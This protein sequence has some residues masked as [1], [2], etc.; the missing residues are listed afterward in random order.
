MAEAAITFLLENLQKLLS[1]HVHLISGAEGELKQLQNELDLMKAFLVQSA[2]RRE[3][4]ELFRQFEIQI[5]D[6]VHEAEDT[7][8]TCLVE[9]AAGMKRNFLSRNLNPKGAS[10]AKK[11]K[12]L[13]ETEVKPIFERAKINFANL[14]IADP[15]ATGDE[16]TKGKAKKIPLL[17]EDNI[18]GFE[19]EADTLISYLN[20]ESEELEVISIIGMPGLGKTTLAWKIY[21]DSRVQFEFPTMIWVYVSQE[22]NRRDVF[23]TILKKFTQVDMSS[24]T[25]NELAC[26]VRSYLEKSKFILF[27]DDVWTTEDWKNIEAALPKGNKLGKVLITSRHERVAV[28]ANR[29][30]EPHQLR[31]LDSTESWELLQLEVFRNLDD[32]PQ[33]FKTLGK[34]IARQCGGVPLAIVV[35]GGMLVESFSPQGGS[36]MKSEWEKISASV[37]SYLADDKEKRT[38]NIIALS[39]KQMSHDLRDC[40]LYLGVFPEDT[41]IHAWKLIRLWIAEGFIKHKPPKSLEEVAEDNLKDLINLNLVMVDKTKAEGGI[42]VC[43][44]HDMIREFCKAEAGIKKQNLFQEVKKSNNVFDPRVS[45]IQ[46]HR[47]ICIHSYVQDFLRGRPK[48]PRVRSFLCFSKETITLPLECIPSIPEAFDLLRVLDANPIK[49]LKFPIKLTQLIHLR[50]IAL[51]GDEFK[52]LPDAVSKLWNLQTIRIDTISRTFEI[53]AN[54]WK[55]RQL[56]HFKTKA[57]ITLSSELKGEAAENLQSLSRLSTQCCTEELFN[58]TPNLINLGIRGDLATLSDSRCLIKLNR[59]QKLKLLYDVFPDVTSENPLSRLAQPDRFPPNLKILELSATHLSWKHMSTLGKLG[60]LKVL[61]LKD[62]AFVGKFWEAGV[63]GKFASLEFLLI[64]RTDLEFWTASSD[65]FPG[66][67]CLVLKNCE[68]L[69][70]IPLLL[71][72]SLQILDIERVSKTAAA[73]ARKIEAEKECMHGQ[74]H[75][76]KR[77]GFKLIIAPGD[78]R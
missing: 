10:L 15:S 78:E 34:D 66:L 38:E 46:K 60:A 23:L 22:F 64:A 29:K 40:F 16:D 33:D 67:K 75:R 61:K 1:D 44:M 58:K 21:K 20:E 72:K 62:F 13:R 63:E 4:G 36:A 42:K 31:F 77:G 73:S 41:E 70:E 43:R 6:V 19:G 52:S 71:H 48:G 47:R 3:K 56:R 74:Q 27:M 30:R 69:E 26:L 24:K 45:Q 12:T 35:I 9:A 17:R 54:I 68:R 32:C 14:Q 59:L 2:N 57:A 7:L 37:N 39:Y 25:D 11:V 18:V 50:Y 76:A 8:D 5:R 65:C 55:M 49:F 53:K 51:S 28:H